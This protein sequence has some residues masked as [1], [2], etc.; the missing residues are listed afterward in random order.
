LLEDIDLLFLPAAER[1]GGEF[2]IQIPAAPIEL[3]K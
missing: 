1:G 3:L 2:S